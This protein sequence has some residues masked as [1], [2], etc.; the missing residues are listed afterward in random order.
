MTSTGTTITP[1]WVM[2]LDDEV[3]IVMIFKKSLA[4]AGYDAFGFSDPFLA[5]E[6]FKANAA[7]YGVI[8]S[9]VRMPRMTGIEFATKVREI[10]PS[11]PIILMSAFEMSTLDIPSALDV[12]SFLQKPLMPKQLNKIVAKYVPMPAK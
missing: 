4:H 8:I 1:K 2:I 3:D 10:S 11:V 5:L 12:A 9:D 6:H 7:G